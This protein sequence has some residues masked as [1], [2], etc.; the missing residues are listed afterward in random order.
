MNLLSC[1]G[2]LNQASREKPSDG[3][4]SE[5]FHCVGS[6]DLR[7]TVP[8][9]ARPSVIEFQLTEGLLLPLCLDP[10]LRELIEL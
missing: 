2:V 5:T 1:L 8:L 9:T 4:S 7:H 6:Q 10:G 3:R